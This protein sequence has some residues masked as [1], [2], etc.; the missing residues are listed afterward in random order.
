MSELRSANE[1]GL[2]PALQDLKSL[3]DDF[4][5]HADQSAI[6]S[7]LPSGTTELSYGEL[8]EKVRRL[9]ASLM[10]YGM[11]K[12][13]RAVIAGANSA[14]WIIA[15]LAVI[16]SGGV[17]V[18][19][20]WAQGSEELKH[21]ITDSA[22]TWIFADE[23]AL[24][25]ILKV[26]PE[27]N[28][29][30][31]RLE[32]CERECNLI[33]STLEVSAEPA[34]GDLAFVFYTSGTSGMPKGV[35]LTHANVC[36][37]LDSLIRKTD[38]LKKGDRLL[39]PLPLY[40]VYPLNVG[41]LSP[42]SLGL[43]VILAAAPTGPEIQRALK[44]GKATVLI[45]VPRLVRSLYNGIDSRVHSNVLLGIFFDM[46]MPV[47]E[48]LSRAHLPNP[49]RILFAALRRKICPCLR[50][51]ACGG[52]LLEDDLSAKINAL[53]W[54][55]SIGYGLTET[56]PLLTVRFPRDKDFSGVGKPIPGVSVRI[57]SSDND[58]EGEIEAKG[59]NIFHGYLNLPELNKTTFTADGW[60][61]TGDLG[62]FENGHLH[63]TGRVS[64]TLVLEGGKKIQPDELEKKYSIDPGIREIGI[65][66][67]DHK[68]VA[69]VFPELAQ[70]LTA[71]EFGHFCGS[72]A[73]ERQDQINR[74]IRRKVS[75]LLQT[76]ALELQPYQ[77]ITDF[78]ITRQ[79]LPRTNLGKLK[80]KE[81]EERFDQARH[82]ESLSRNDSEK[83]ENI[84]PADQRLLDNESA[85]KTWD[86][87]HRLFPEQTLTL[88]SSP[89]LDLNVDSFEWMNLSLE[90]MEETGVELS[91]Q[92]IVRIGTLRDLLC[93]IVSES[94]T[95]QSDGTK[96]PLAN[97]ETF[98]SKEQQKWLQPLN[99]FQ[100]A[101]SLFCYW[102]IYLIMHA[103][104]RISSTGAEQLCSKQL[105]FIPNHASYLDIFALMS[106][107]PYSRLR[108]TQIAA[109]IG[110][111]FANPFNSF[112]SRLGQTFP[113]DSR[114]SLISSLALAAAVLK[115]GKGLIWFPEGERTLTGQLLP[116]KPGI[117]LLLEDMELPVVP[118][119][120]QGTREALPPGAFI[121]RFFRK[122]TV[123][124][125][126]PISPSRLAAEGVGN[127]RAERIANA[128]HDRVDSL[129]KSSKPNSCLN[130]LLDLNKGSKSRFSQT[131]SGQQ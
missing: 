17:A 29:K 22:A 116:F 103:F 70:I 27:N 61:K 57:A 76:V 86:L 106:V 98:L 129:Y 6:V 18:P 3:L 105:V 119:C 78:T 120:L 95:R 109:W 90:I 54:D 71:D 94:Q 7:V 41:L 131:R 123:I 69:L 48:R 111:A 115:N 24:V 5:S 26:F 125:G 37:Q 75:G 34:S 39:I 44:E 11:R 79:P 66:Q 80:R 126:E 72:E 50:M 53:G 40:H 124:F 128:L 81:L 118:T 35:P 73:R 87:L 77:R 10:N 74:E 63:I 13:D 23:Q 99:A 25:N 84:S 28:F 64:N 107:L 85:A 38:L 8:L 15:C 32:Q 16:Y 20:D 47:C 91:E 4:D 117:G 30:V 43:S 60:F 114:N 21:I 49:G 108:N 33:E 36:L 101:L 130:E 42:L 9:S 113:I 46:M 55:L 52:A 127:T 31:F 56:A 51:F 112:M 68:L 62:R 92:S 121:P 122:V 45:S 93:E 97:P 59:P 102:L 14:E 110:I 82:E 100:S 89:Q 19:V 2:H 67:K 104:F 58:D 65:L 1:A 88:D 83:V 12:A 96:T